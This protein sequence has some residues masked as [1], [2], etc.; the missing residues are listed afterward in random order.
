[1]F[2]QASVILST[3]GACLAGGVCWE[4]MR[5][6]GAC[7]VGG[8]CGRGHAWQGACMAEGG[9][10]V[11]KGV[12]VVKEGCA[13][14][15]GHAWYA[16]SPPA[17]LRDTACQ[18][19]GGTHPTGMHS[20][21]KNAITK[22][23]FNSIQASLMHISSSSRFTCEQYNSVQNGST[24]Q[25]VTIVQFVRTLPQLALKIYNLYK[26]AT[27]LT[28]SPSSLLFVCQLKSFTSVWI[29]FQI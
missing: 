28:P 22:C 24:P 11:A 5:G 1:M 25:G 29:T 23:I 20:C 6:Q 21:I 27:N 8:M 13:W 3:G 12:C 10:C 17:L 26:F 4:D 15:G 14:Q 19:A 2:L 7:V 16:P 9:G 18:C